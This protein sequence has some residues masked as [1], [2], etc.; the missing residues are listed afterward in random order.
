M[1]KGG[2]MAGAGRPKGAKNKKIPLVKI[3]ES[4]A[5]AILVEEL[6]KSWRKHIRIM[7][8]VAYG[9]TKVIVWQ[10]KNMRVYERAPDTK[11]LLELTSFVI[12]KPKQEIGGTLNLPEIKNLTDKIQSILERK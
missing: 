6:L 2:R 4:E 5:R 1:S 3:A 9:K 11:M 10:G 7:R 8:K 12:G